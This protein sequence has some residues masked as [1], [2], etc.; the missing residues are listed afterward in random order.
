MGSASHAWVLV[1]CN[2]VPFLAFY[3][4]SYVILF[5]T[6]ILYFCCSILNKVVKPNQTKSNQ[7][8][9]TKSNQIKSNQIKSNQIKSNQ[10]KS[11]QIKSINFWIGQLVKVPIRRCK[12]WI[13]QRRKI[14]LVGRKL[15]LRGLFLLTSTQESVL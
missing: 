4:S 2:S 3:L 13:L 1:S 10:I 6:Y 11:N 5:V 7:G 8:N 14:Y 9:Q 15:Y 12:L